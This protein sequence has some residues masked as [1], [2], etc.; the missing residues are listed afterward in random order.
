[1]SPSA[2]AVDKSSFFR[3]IS[4]FIVYAP[5]ART[6]LSAVIAVAFG[7]RDEQSTGNQLFVSRDHVIRH[8]GNGALGVGVAAAEITARAHEHVNDGLELFVTEALDR[9]GLARAPQD[10]DKGGWKIV[11]MLFVGR[12]GRKI[13]RPA[14]VPE[15]LE[16]H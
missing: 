2:M 14:N 11:E 13:Y 7:G 4:T 1:M 10:T 12:Q 8:G 5:I 16:R 3:G 15:D 9:A 6:M